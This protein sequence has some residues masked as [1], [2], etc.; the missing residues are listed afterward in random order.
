M[1]GLP[2][3]PP[4]EAEDT[5]QFLSRMREVDQR[6]ASILNARHD[7]RFATLNRKRR[8]P[9][10][11][12]VA[13]IVWY[14]PEPQPGTDKLAPR[15]RRGLVKERVGTFSYVVEIAEGVLRDAHRSQLK[16]HHED[17]FSKEPLPLFYFSGKASPV[18]MQ[19]D[20]WLVESIHGHRQGPKGLEFLVQ[21]K[22]WDPTD[23]TWE[24]WTNFFPSY[25]E[26]FVK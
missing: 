25:N 15:W 8:D 13:A 21:W 20:E 16:P 6:V 4:H 24:P 12:E 26:D 1:Q 14:R 19:M 11:F 3:Q 5:L 22:G 10:P 17:E 23:R 18:P 9:P 2:Y 7:A